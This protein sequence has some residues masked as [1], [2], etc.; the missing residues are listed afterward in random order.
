MKTRAGDVM[1]LMLFLVG[2][3][4]F[5]VLL[6]LFAYAP[7]LRREEADPGNASSRA[8][9]G[10]AGLKQLMDLSGIPTQTDRGSAQ[11]TPS[12]TIL[13]PTVQTTA[14][15]WQDYDEHSPVL[16]ILPKWFTLP[17]PLHPGWVMKTGAWPVGETS[18]MIAPLTRNKVVQAPGD[19]RGL[20]PSVNPRFAGLPDRI[21]GDLQQL[22][23][24]PRL[25][26]AVLFLDL[27]GDK[28][29]EKDGVAVVIQ[30]RKGK[31]PIYVL[32]D[33]D[34][35][36]NQGLSDPAMAQMALAIINDLREGKGPVR[37]DLTL[38]ATRHKPS[39]LK[40]A[41]EPPFRGAT[42]CALLA[43]LLM[44]LHALARFGA[45]L[46]GGRVLARG[47]KALA[48]NTADL[49]RMMGREG[50][51]APRYV[52]AMRNLVLARL[53]SRVRGQAEQDEMLARLELAGGSD[54]AYGQLVAEASRAR[55]GSDLL[56]IADR[57]Y[58]WKGRITSEHS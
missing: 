25:D 5:I 21:A 34:L 39:L 48:R 3:A 7:D 42:I 55:T 12:L 40:A 4:A 17:M 52:A 14:Q 11:G 31:N 50:A 38:N 57:A 43:A 6:A 13:T 26:N 8:A 18:H 29:L 20:K 35:M 36:D 33:P 30:V 41:F 53:G 47:K 58:A 22:Q 2:S 1:P 51:M 27:P 16:I 9:I 15:D 45:P 19:F 44:A 46:A 24:F 23:Y 32:S 10:F 37:L 28:R 49:V 54:I 56:A